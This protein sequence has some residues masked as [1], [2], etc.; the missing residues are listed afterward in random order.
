MIGTSNSAI[1]VSRLV[2]PIAPPKKPTCWISGSLTFGTCE[3]FE[4][5][6][7]LP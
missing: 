1:H 4:G 5:V 2:L 3:M 6:P 7:L